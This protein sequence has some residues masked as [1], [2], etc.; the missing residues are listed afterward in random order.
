M[1]E[2]DDKNGAVYGDIDEL[3]E[4]FEP[5]SSK[6]GTPIE[7]STRDQGG[8]T[9]LGAETLIPFVDSPPSPLK[10]NEDALPNRGSDG[11]G[12]L[13]TERVE[14]HKANRQLRNKYAS[15]AYNLACGGLVFWGVA[16]SATAIAYGATGRQ[17]FS[18]KVLIAITT[19]ATINVLAAFLGVIRGLF[20]SG[21]EQQRSKREV[22]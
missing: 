16:I 21:G 10:S 18:D 5:A 8:E 7:S 9:A 6:V 11:Q 2:V 4:Q 3:E 15:K 20:P 13:V 17:M 14:D 22:A 1:S 12:R 19:G